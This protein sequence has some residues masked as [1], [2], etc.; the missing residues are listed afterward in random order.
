VIPFAATEAARK[1]AGDPRPSIA[2]RYADDDA[3]VAA[4][5]KEAERQVAERLLLPEDAERSIDAARQGKLAKLT[6]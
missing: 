2:E 5:R 3:Y 6:Q 1:E 4:I